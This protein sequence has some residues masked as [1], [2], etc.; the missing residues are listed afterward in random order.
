MSAI[1]SILLKGN[2]K[3]KKVNYRPCP[4][5]EFSNGAWNVC[6]NAISYNCHDQNFKSDCSISCNFV[7]GQKFSANE[8]S[9]LT[10]QLPMVLFHVET[11]E[12]SLS[13]G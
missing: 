8:D 13:I 4:S 5:S 7:R 2:F 1:K 12:K 11:G 3:D 9:I 10:Y 6:I